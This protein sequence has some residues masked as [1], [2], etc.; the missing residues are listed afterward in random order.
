MNIFGI[1]F[2]A[3]FALV[4]MGSYI[5]IRRG[6]LD[7][8]TAGLL[9]GM[10]S[11]GAMIGFSLTQNLAVEYALVTGIGIGAVFTIA[12]MIMASFFQ[13]NQPNARD[14]EVLQGKPPS[15]NG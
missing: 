3:M 13:N 8:R 14:L 12:L 6:L 10:G 4:Q 2:L 15:E 1:G 9:C 7:L 11:I 5:G